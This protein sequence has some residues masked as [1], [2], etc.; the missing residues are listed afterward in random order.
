MHFLTPVLHPIVTYLAVITLLTNAP[1]PLYRARQARRR[2]PSECRQT[3][4]CVSKPVVSTKV[5][6]SSYPPS[7]SSPRLSVFCHSTRGM[8]EGG[9]GSCGYSRGNESSPFPSAC[10]GPVVI[11]YSALNL[12]N[13]D[14][15]SWPKGGAL[16]RVDATPPTHGCSAHRTPPGSP[17]EN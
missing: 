12:R 14:A 13:S 3:P 5:L 7:H 15:L 8:H 9:K 6:T 2:K 10:I 1:P 17:T 16:A 11:P 4:V